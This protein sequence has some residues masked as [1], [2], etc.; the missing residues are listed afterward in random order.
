MVFAC[1]RCT[2]AADGRFDFPLLHGG[3]FRNLVAILIQQPHI[4]QELQVLRSVEANVG[5]SP[6]RTQQTIAL[7]PSTNGMGFD[8]REM[9]EVLDG[10]FLH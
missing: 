10:K 3:D 8:P 9:F 7:F 5:R 6:S 4:Q 2:Q 1:S